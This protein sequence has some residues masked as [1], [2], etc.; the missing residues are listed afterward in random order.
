M[1]YS[2]RTAWVDSPDK[3]CSS[4]GSST[5]NTPNAFDRQFSRERLVLYQA[6][7]YVYIPRYLFFVTP[8]QFQYATAIRGSILSV[9]HSKFAAAYYCRNG[10]NFLLT[11]G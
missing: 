8:I 6:F 3:G 4:F 11:Y 5:L 10:E 9:V 7:Q 1:K 2:Q